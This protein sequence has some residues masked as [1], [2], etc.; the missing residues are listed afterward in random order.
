M[1]K[2]VSGVVV[3]VHTPFDRDENI[4]LEGLERLIEHL[5]KNKIKSIFILSSV[6]EF[7][8]ITESHKDALVKYSVKFAKGRLKIFCGVS[9]AGTKRVIE[10]MKRL[11]KYDICAYATMLPYFY[12]QRRQEENLE[13]LKQVIKNA[14]KP[15]VYYNNPGLTGRELTPE[16]YRWMKEQKEIVGIKDSS[17]KLDIFKSLV[18]IFSDRKDFGLLTGAGD[19]A[20]ESLKLG[21]D[22]ITPGLGTIIPGLCVDLYACAKSG[23]WDKCKLLQEKYTQISKKING[24]F[25]YW[26]GT[27]KNALKWLGIMDDYTAS[28]HLPIT[29]EKSEY[30]RQVLVE[31]GIVKG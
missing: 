30:I 31:Y 16:E 25:V 26:P 1:E 12:P 7:A 17:G 19:Q 4:D 23:D 9:D 24:D 28:P 20:Y 3:P 22:G 2:L 29:E 11:S 14:D 13:F 27:Q 10:N 15:V 5:V 18:E 21:G 6:G 8:R